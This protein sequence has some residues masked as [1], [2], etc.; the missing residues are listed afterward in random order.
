MLLPLNP[1]PVQGEGA[2]AGLRGGL[3]REAEVGVGGPPRAPQLKAI[4]VPRGP[5][6]AAPS[7][8]RAP[9]NLEGG[10]LLGLTPPGAKGGALEGCCECPTLVGGGDTQ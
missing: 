7:V 2:A 5:P 8:S 6:R 1:P 3:W 10:A 9:P 4:A